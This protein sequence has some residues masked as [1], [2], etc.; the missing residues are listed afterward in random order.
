M[1]EIEK[2]YRNAGLSNMWVERYN[3]GYAQQE[4]YH[5]SYRE[6]I[7]NMMK[8][9]DWTLTEAQEV[10]KNDCRKE[11]PSFTAEKQLKIEEVILEN[12]AYDKHLE[13]SKTNN[14]KWIVMFT[15]TNKLT[16]SLITLQK[17]REEA[18]AKLIN[19]L[20]Q[21]LTDVEKEQIK[22]ILND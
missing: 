16:P 5:N 8:A 14:G 6:M 21:D 12:V 7:N 3:N 11:Y 1:N 18:L 17:T 2:M 9:N 15:R 4:I 19:S 20:W 13:Y 22:G 10:A